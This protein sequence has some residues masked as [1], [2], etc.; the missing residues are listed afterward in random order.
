MKLKIP[1]SPFSSYFLSELTLRCVSA[2]A[3]TFS[4]CVLISLFPHTPKIT[5]L[6]HVSTFQ[7]PFLESSSFYDQSAFFFFFFLDL[8]EESEGWDGSEEEEKPSSQPDVVE[9]QELSKS[10]PEPSLMPDCN[11]WNVAH[12]RLSVFRSLR[13]MRQVRKAADF[14]SSF[15]L[16]MLFFFFKDTFISCNLHIPWCCVQHSACPARNMM[17]TGELH[18]WAHS[19][20]HVG[21]WWSSVMW[22]GVR[23]FLSN[24]ALLFF[25]RTV[26]VI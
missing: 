18:L 6:Q 3:S 2:A 9:G 1:S 25:P 17:W 11:S 12:R 26:A 23:W 8:K 13:H 19:L 14:T 20:P 5:W 22:V 7:F 15:L 16:I 10:S 21:L 4:Y 24:S